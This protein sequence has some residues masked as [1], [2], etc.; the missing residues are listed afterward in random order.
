M[1]LETIKKKISRKEYC[2]LESFLADIKW[3][4]HNAHV[5]KAPKLYDI[6]DELVRKAEEACQEIE[7]CPNCVLNAT[8]FNFW[9]IQP[10]AHF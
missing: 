3:I 4:Q 9:F 6:A 8:K 2:S 1:S 5:Y 7:S 10:K